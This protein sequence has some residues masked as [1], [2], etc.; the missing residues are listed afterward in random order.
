MAS[1]LIVPESALVN[2]GS[3]ALV[4][5]INADTSAAVINNAK[6]QAL[7]HLGASAFTAYPISL[8]NDTNALG[9]AWTWTGPQTYTYGAGAGLVVDT[10]GNAGQA[11]LI[12]KASST[13]TGGAVDRAAR[14]D[15]IQGTSILW[16]LISDYQQTGSGTFDLVNGSNVRVLTFQ[17]NGAASFAELLTASTGAAIGTF[18]HPTS[19]VQIEMGY[20]GTEGVVQAYDRTNG[21]P[22]PLWLNYGITDVY[23]GGQVYIHN[24][25]WLASFDT[26][27][28]PHGIVQIDSSNRALL[29]ADTAGG[30]GTVWAAI[31]GLPKNLLSDAN[32]AAS[33]A[34]LLTAA[35]GIYNNLGNLSQGAPISGPGFDILN[36]FDPIDRYP[37]GES[38]FGTVGAGNSGFGASYG[39]VRT[40]RGYGDDQGSGTVGFPFQVVVTE[41]NGT[42]Y[43][44]VLS[45]SQPVWAASTAYAL[46]AYIMPTQV[47]QN[48]WYFQCTVAGTS[49]TTEPAWPSTSGGT[50]VDGTVTWKAV[51]EFWGPWWSVGVAGYDAQWQVPQT[52]TAPLQTSPGGVVLAGPGGGFAMPGYLA[53]EFFLLG[54]PGPA[55]TASVSTAGS[56]AASWVERMR[57]GGNAAQG[58]A[59]ISVYEPTTFSQLVAFSAGITG[60]GSVGS[61]TVPWG[62]LTSVPSLVNTFNGRTGAVDPA[63][64]DYTPTMVGFSAYP[65]SLSADTNALGGAWT[66]TGLQ[67]LSGGFMDSGKLGAARSGVTS[68]G[69][70]AALMCKNTGT[71]GLTYWWDSG[72]SGAGIGEGNFAVY[73]PGAAV[74]IPFGMN[75]TTGKVYT[76]KNIL[77]DGSGNATFSGTI[78]VSGDTLYWPSFMAQ[79][80]LPTPIGIG[81]VSGN[82]AGSYVSGQLNYFS[83]MLVWGSGVGSSGSLLCT[84]SAN[85]T[86]TIPMWF[87]LEPEQGESTPHGSIVVADDVRLLQ[88][89]LNGS[90]IAGFAGPLYVLSTDTEGTPPIAFGNQQGTKAWIDQNGNLFAAGSITGGS[91][92][93]TT[94]GGNF[95]YTVL[96]CGTGTN[97][98]SGGPANAGPYGY[99]STVH[100]QTTYYFE[101]VGENAGGSAN[102]TVSLLDTTAGSLVVT[103]TGTPT[104]GFGVYRTGSIGVT[105]GH[106]YGIQITNA[107]VSL[108]RIVGV[109]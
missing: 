72:S 26:S 69:T 46:N 75:A 74:P 14:I 71:G 85:A 7:V 31:N 101:F 13:S 52:F 2:D 99:L 30:P 47:N 70:D 89:Q 76:N 55:W 90:T 23:L 48:G 24:T 65:I 20:D 42:Q 53:N 40:T 96:I 104:S 41:N 67:T 39:T 19:G 94:L 100:G 108:A 3:G 102:M 37:E 81:L 78:N 61:L 86:S 45:T 64:G 83:G 109:V 73:S 38:L 12:L 88:F 25:K 8:A 11:D 79:G 22:V 17:P 32:G 4:G 50:V 16:T 34:G 10:S 62:N 103:Y 84:T 58:G 93:A 95:E 92:Q 44:R 56:G 54:Q 97:S 59:G 80:S 63:S 87:G 66:W 57:F 68:S 106:Q 60:T 91:V 21:V 33:I 49:G 107:N 28:G 1:F 5:V 35:A 77:D 82:P 18:N 43:R 29:N 27:G 9:N 36:S 51:G 6:V 105:A 98:D 15:F